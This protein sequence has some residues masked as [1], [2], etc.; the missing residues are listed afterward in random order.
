MSFAGS[1]NSEQQICPIAIA[2][3]Q[4]DVDAPAQ[5]SWGVVTCDQCGAKYAIGPNRYYGFR[6]PVPSYVEMI[7]ALLATDHL[8]S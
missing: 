2:L 6:L 8:S 7:E 5:D 1:S 3:G 4:S